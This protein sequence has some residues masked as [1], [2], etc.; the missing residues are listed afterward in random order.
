VAHEWGLVDVFMLG[1][2]V[3]LIKLGNLADVVLGP[4]LWSFGCLILVV[5]A[6]GVFFNPRE[7]WSD[8]AT[9]Q[10]LRTRRRR[11]ERQ[12]AESLS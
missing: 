11:R 1:V 2:V 6:I 10:A 8:A 3:S 12:L 7:L 4:A 9:Y 5:T